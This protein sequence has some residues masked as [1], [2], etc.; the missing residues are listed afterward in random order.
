MMFTVGR[1][2]RIKL[3]VGSEVINKAGYNKAFYYFRYYDKKV[4]D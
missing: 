3:F 2:M 4:R 1:L